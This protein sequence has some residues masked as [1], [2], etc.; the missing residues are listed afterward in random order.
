MLTIRRG[1]EDLTE[2]SAGNA[3][4]AVLKCQDRHSPWELPMPPLRRS[5]TRRRSQPRLF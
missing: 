5:P 4:L 1:A 3:Q 2:I